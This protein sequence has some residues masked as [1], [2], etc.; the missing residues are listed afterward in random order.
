MGKRDYRN[1]TRNVD[2]SVW[3]ND[4]GTVSREWLQVAVLMDIREELREIRRIVTCHNTIDIPRILRR[5]AT[6]TT[7]TR[8]VKK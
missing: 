3:I 4:D 1:A 5:I 7:K 8:K 6:N 2:W